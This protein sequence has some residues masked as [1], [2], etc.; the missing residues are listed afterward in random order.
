MKR[1]IKLTKKSLD[2]L[3][4]T[5]DVIPEEEQEWYWGMYE[6]VNLAGSQQDVGVALVE[7]FKYYESNSSARLLGDL[8]DLN[9]VSWDRSSKSMQKGTF[10]F[11]GYTFTFMVYNGCGFFGQSGDCILNNIVGSTPL[12]ADSGI[13]LKNGTSNIMS[14]TTTNPD[15]GKALKSYI[16][17]K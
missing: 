11:Q 2:E 17:G 8:V 10:T 14:I 7:A 16:N 15:A 9:S 4:R 13:A 6:P 12:N 5:M 3:A 1:E